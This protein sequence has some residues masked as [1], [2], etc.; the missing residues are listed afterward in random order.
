MQYIKLYTRSLE[1]SLKELILKHDSFN[2]HV[3]KTK[4]SLH[5]F[6]GKIVILNSSCYELP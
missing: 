5:E 3:A 6:R 4:S 2:S 1:E